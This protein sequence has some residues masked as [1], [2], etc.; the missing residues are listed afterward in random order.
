[1]N[2]KVIVACCDTRV[3]EFVVTGMGKF[4]DESSI[5]VCRT[6]FELYNFIAE[7]KDTVIIFDK[8]FLGYLL[9]YQFLRLKV[10]NDEVS[11][12][13]VEVGNCSLYFGLRVYDLGTNGFIANIE[14]ETV[15]NEKFKM[16]LEGYTVFPS[17]IIQSLRT[18]NKV[19]IDKKIYSEV[20]AREMEVGLYLGMGKSRK[21]I[22]S[23]TGLTAS[24]ISQHIYRLSKKVG[25]KHEKDYEM[26][27][28]QALKMKGGC[29]AI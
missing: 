22:C 24:C 16:I 1:M 2:K 9:S 8:F 28:R 18:G 14:N 17:E 3:R 26:L 10:L 23:L 21:E 12:Y 6:E 7:S 25:F 5:I 19:Q 15:R 29:I 11:T 13:F 27:C 20:T 4:L